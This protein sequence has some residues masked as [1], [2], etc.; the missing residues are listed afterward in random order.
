MIGPI[1][2]RRQARPKD[3]VCVTGS[4]L[5][6]GETNISGSIVQGVKRFKPFQISE[7]GVA[8]RIF[9]SATHDKM[10]IH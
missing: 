1:T 2:A 6:L 5:L 8:A 7:R 3:L 9:L 10:L 4:L